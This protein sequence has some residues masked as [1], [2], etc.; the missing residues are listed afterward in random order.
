MQY[1]LPDCI[2]RLVGVDARKPAGLGVKAV[3]IALRHTTEKLNRLGFKFVR[4][5]CCGQALGYRSRL[6]AEPGR[7]ARIDAHQ[8]RDAVWQGVLQ[9]F[10]AKGWL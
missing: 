5:T 2:A 8:T 7:F 4:H 9:V 1:A 6:T 3:A 10:T